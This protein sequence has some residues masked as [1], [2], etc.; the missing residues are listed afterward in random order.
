M[1]TWTDIIYVAAGF[2]L[3]ALCLTVALLVAE[4]IREEVKKNMNEII[5]SLAELKQQVEANTAQTEKARLEVVQ[6]IADLEAAIAD[7]AGVPEALAAL[8][9]AVNQGTAAS[10][11][12]DDVVPDAAPPAPEPTPTEP[13]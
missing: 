2:G 6:K 4:K 12:I 5:Q 10:Q 1:T 9:A 7:N 3:V 11:A 13:V 8:K